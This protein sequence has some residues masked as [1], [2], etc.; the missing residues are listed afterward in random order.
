MRLDK[1]A[2][3]GE[4]E[5]KSEA[6]ITFAVS[7]LQ[8][9][10][11][12]TLSRPAANGGWSIAQ[13]LAHLNSYG[14]YYLPAID[15]ALGQAIPIKS[16]CFTPSILGQ[17]FTDLMDPEKGK[18][19]FKAFK[20]HIPDENLDPIATVSAFIAQQE[21]FVSLIRKSEE[22]D[23]QQIKIPI[24]LSRWVH[25]PLGDVFNFIHA[26]NERHILQ[27]RRNL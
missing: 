2:F 23:I 24:S 27:M 25:I 5:S 18:T 12:E 16:F 3:L 8:N 17:Y 22:Y 26:H 6:Q 10:P 20:K 1:F 15:K 13:V 11:N 4:L 7:I 9:L 19:K 21:S 14:D